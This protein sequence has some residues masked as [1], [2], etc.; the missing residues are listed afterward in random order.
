MDRRDKVA[1]EFI[2]KIGVTQPAETGKG[3][4]DFFIS[5]LLLLI[6]FGGLAM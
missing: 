6:A 5:A 1:N 4:E 3:F 2:A